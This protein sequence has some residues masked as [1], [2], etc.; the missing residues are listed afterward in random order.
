MSG[1]KIPGREPKSKPAGDAEALV[2]LA[3]ENG[4][5]G[6]RESQ[7][8]LRVPLE[9][10]ALVS[11]AQQLEEEGRIRILGFTPLHVIA[12]ASLDFLSGKI[13][14]VLSRHHAARPEECGL[15]LDK[16]RH[17]LDA[18]PKVLNLAVKLLVHD[19]TLRRE[20]SALALAGFA[21]RLPPRE[22]HLLAA[23]EDCCR[24]G[25]GSVLIPD[26]IR[27]DL[28]VTPQKLESLSAILVERAR[29]VRT[30]EGYVILK[31]WFDGVVERIRALPKGE[32]KVAT[33]KEI[34]GLSRKF[35]IPLLEYLDETGVTRRNGSLRE[36]IA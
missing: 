7:A 14:A 36:V 12:R 35:A 18:P 23:F 9:H 24:R 28:R 30:K 10:D 11:L 5:K 26:V 17:R 1:R 13:V 4:L 8:R 21:R 34:T 29:I 25:P 27:A 2:G 19:G 15:P 6:A 32:L 22:E 31:P 20:G 3:R 33:F 16:L